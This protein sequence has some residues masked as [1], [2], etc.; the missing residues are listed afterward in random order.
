MGEILILP[1]VPGRQDLLTA[2]AGEKDL[3]RL[4]AG[5]QDLTEDGRYRLWVPED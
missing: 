3:L 4:V 5:M 1:A 2:I